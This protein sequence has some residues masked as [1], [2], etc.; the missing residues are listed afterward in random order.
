MSRHLSG[1]IFLY[2]ITGALGGFLFGFDV[3][4]IAG[5]MPFFQAHFQLSVWQLGI[6]NSSLLFGCIAGSIVAGRITDEYGPRKILSV[7]AILFALTSVGCAVSPSPLLLVISRFLGGLAVGAVSIASPVYI[8]EISPPDSRGR[9]VTLYQLSIT[10]GILLSLLIN[11][12]LKDSWANW[13]LMFASGIVP[14]LVFLFL[15]LKIPETPRFLVRKG[16]GSEA[17]EVLL[18]ICEPELADQTVRE[19]EASFNH[20]KEKLSDLFRPGIRKAILVGFVLAVL[21]QASGIAAVIDYAPRILQKSGM[22]IDTALLGT[23]GIGFINFLFTFVSIIL[24]DR[25]G[26]K[27]LYIIG[28]AGIMLASLAMAVIFFADDHMGSIVFLMCLVYI[29]FFAACLGPVFWTLLPE[30]FPNKVRGLAMTI[31]VLTQWLVNALVVMVFPVV[32]DTTPGIAFLF[33]AVM[34]ALQLIFTIGFVPET[35]RKSLEEIEG[36]WTKRP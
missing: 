25:M 32:F 28:S 17:H 34:A 18:T 16:R 4:I 3:A 6:V 10:A 13:R 21:I 8:A 36:F 15:L 23:A 14:S 35:K 11:F 9:Y 30:L 29:V 33:M 22:G 7:V 27:P 24:I 2:A 19:I 20:E 12:L 31:P 1:N 5:A 26:R